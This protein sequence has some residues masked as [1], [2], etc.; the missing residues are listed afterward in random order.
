MNKYIEEF[1]SRHPN[2]AISK[3]SVNSFQYRLIGLISDEL[4]RSHDFESFKSIMTGMEACMMIM[5]EWATRN[6]GEK[7]IELVQL[8]IQ[9]LNDHMLLF[10]RRMIERKKRE[11]GG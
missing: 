10:L 3:L 9:E 2:S 11:N 6:S 4:A 1:I 7:Q 5:F 8:S